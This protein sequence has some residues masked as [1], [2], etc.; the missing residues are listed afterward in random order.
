MKNTK[1]NLA[2]IGPLPD[3][4]TGIS[5]ANKVAVDYLSGKYK[6]ILFNTSDFENNHDTFSIKK[7]FLIVRLLFVFLIKIFRIN[8]VYICLGQTKF[9]FLKFSFFML[10]AFVFRKPAIV[11]VHGNRIK[12]TY[13]SSNR[14]FQFYIR[15]I[16]KIPKKF[17]F[18]SPNLYQNVKELISREKIEIVPNFV[19]K[20][21]IVNNIDVKKMD[22][23]RIIFLSNLIKSKGILE[24]LEAVKQ[25]HKK[26]IKFV[27]NVAGNFYSSEIKTEFTK[28]K[29]ILG[30][31]FI[32]HG[33]VKGKQ[34][35]DILVN[36]NLF[37]LPTYYPNEAQPISILEAMGSGNVIITTRN[38]GIPDIIKEKKNGFFV[39][40]KSSK[41]VAKTIEKIWTDKNLL[42]KIM[43][44]NIAEAARNFQIEQFCSNVERVIHS[45]NRV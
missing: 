5:Y 41:S 22:K 38:G 40:E 39:E 10:I 18:L 20:E 16:L 14:F 23:I 33:F 29:E 45:Q 2:F 7:T 36:S 1:N 12:N 15:K 8:T 28:T 9:G 21:F 25:L 31:K 34:K 4:V 35:R 37:V 44:N 19:K 43:T 42:K 13:Y 6:T 27:L 32:Y 17:I 24:L 30:N 11:H 3:P 26:G